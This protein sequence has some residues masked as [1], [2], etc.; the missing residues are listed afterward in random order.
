MKLNIV[1]LLILLLL[2]TVTVY[3]A[4]ERA[5]KV[6]L[7]SNQADMKTAQ[8][9]GQLFNQSNVEY[10]ILP[11][12]SFEDALRQY[13]VLILLGG[14][15]AYDGMGNI[16]SNY[17][18]PKN[19]TTLINEPRTFIV[20][21]YEGNREI[22][23]LAGHTRVETF[24]AV[25]YFFK[26]LIRV[27][28]LWRWVGYPVD[29]DENSSAIYYVQEYFYNKEKGEFKKGK[30]RNVVTQVNGVVS[31]NGTDLYN[32]TTTDSYIYLGVNYT[33]FT[34]LLLDDLG[35]PYS[36]E[37]KRFVEDRLNSTVN[38]LEYRRAQGY[39]FVAIRMEATNDRVYWE[40]ENRRL[41]RTLIYPIG[42]RNIKAD[43]VI[44]YLFKYPSWE[45]QDEFDIRYINPTIPFG[46]L[47]MR[48]HNIIID[49]DIITKEKMELVSFRGKG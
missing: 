40:I 22:I 11:P 7:L 19:A 30:I 45:L 24:E 49:G 36:C 18:P 8:F 5:P 10:T 25:P 6:A 46:G 31:V 48:I 29:F 13:E 3:S 12:D 1:P 21:I 15:R 39:V 4:E 14:P 43:L 27:T 20:S 44:R 16:T 26:D 9:I 34:E 37:M 32:V 23:V 41:R 17:I 2:P 28:K 42:T 35:R 33:T 47:V 38:C